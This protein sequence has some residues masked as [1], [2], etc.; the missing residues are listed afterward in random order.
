MIL[1]IRDT[2]NQG[3]AIISP[4]TEVRLFVPFSTILLMPIPAFAS[5]F[6]NFCEN[7]LYDN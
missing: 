5:D 6:I 7:R 3:G 1:F 4:F 2:Q